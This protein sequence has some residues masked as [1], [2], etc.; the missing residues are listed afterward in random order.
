MILEDAY[1]VDLVDTIERQLKQYARAEE[2]IEKPHHIQAPA[3]ATF[4]AQI[5]RLRE[6]LDTHSAPERATCV[7]AAPAPVAHRWH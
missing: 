1:I 2:I 7:E 3:L 4:N 6:L 5:R